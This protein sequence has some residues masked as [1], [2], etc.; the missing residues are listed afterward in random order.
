MVTRAAT[1]F[2]LLLLA[3]FPAAAQYHSAD[4]NADQQISLSEL[5]RVIQFFNS[6]GLHCQANTEDGYAPGAGNTAC[7]PHS[8]DY[9]PQDWTMSVSELLRT[10]QFFN[11]GGYHAGCGTEDRFAPGVDSLSYCEGDVWFV[12]SGASGDGTS[13]DSAFASIQDAVDAAYAAGGGE[14]WVAA[15]SYTGSTDPVLLMR[16]NTAIYGG[17]VGTEA[18]RAERDWENNET[19]INGESER[20]CVY[21]AN[22]AILDGCVIESGFAEYDG[23]SE[24]GGGMFNDT[25]SPTVNN[26]SFVGNTAYYGGGMCN[27]SS[28]PI[29]NGC[30]FIGNEGDN[31]AGIYNEYSS[32]IL[33]GCSFCFNTAF[34]CG[35]GMSDASSSVILSNCIFDT[36]TGRG[37]PLPENWEYYVKS[38]GGALCS[39]DSGLT[40][41][42][43]AFTGNHADDGGGV[44][45]SNASPVTFNNCEFTMNTGAIG[46]GLASYSSS[47][48]ISNCTFFQNSVAFKSYCIQDIFDGEICY[49]FGGTGGGMSNSGGSPAV[50]NCLFFG[51]TAS[52]TVANG[53]G[54]YNNH[55]SPFICNCTLTQNSA[56]YGGGIYNMAYSPTITNSILWDDVGCSE[57][58]EI[59]CAANTFS[60]VVTFSCVQ[61][62]RD[63]QG[64]ISSDPLLLGTADSE[65]RISPMSPCIDTGTTTGAPS[66]DIRGVARFQGNG[67]DMGVYEL[68]D[69]DG[70]GISDTWEETHFGSL[71]GA[72]V[73]SDADGDGLSDLNESL[74]GTDPALQDTD[75][76]GLSDGEEAQ[77]GLNPTAPS[78]FRRVRPGE[79][80]GIPDGLSWETAFVT[81]Q[82]AVDAVAA[83]G[84]GEV[85][86]A[87]G[88]YTGAGAYVVMMK[89][90]VHIYGG[91]A[92]TETSRDERD[93]EDNRTII[94]GE[95]ARRCVYGADHA[96][97]NGFIVRKGYAA[98][99]GGGMHNRAVSPL[100]AN[101][102]FFENTGYYGGGMGNVNSSPRLSNCI[103]TENSAYDG[104]GMH[105]VSSYPVLANCTLLGNI[106]T[107]AGTGI[108]NIDSSPN[109]VNCILWDCLL[110]DTPKEIENWTT[111]SVPVITYSCVRG[112]YDGPGNIA[113]DP[114][115]RGTGEMAGRIQPT[116]PCID[117][118]TILGAAVSD[119]RGV[120]RPQGSGSDMGA[121]EL[122]DSDGDGISDSWEQQHFG[123]LTSA[124]ASSDGDAD[125]LSDLQESLYGTNPFLTD[126]DGDGFSDGEE[127]EHEWEPLLPTAVRRVSSVNISGTEDGLSWATA[128]S[129]IQAAIDDVAVV[130]EGEVWVR[131]GVYTG[132]GD[133][134]GVLKDHVHLYG[135][136]AGTETNHNE[137]DWRMNP[138]IID[139]ESV[140]RC[141]H[142]SGNTVLDGFTV[143]NGAGLDGGGMYNDAFSE[144]GVCHCI[145]SGNSARRHGGGIF[146]DNHASAVVTDC[147]FTRNAA[148]VYGGGIAAD[149]HSSIAIMNCVFTDN[150]AGLDGGAVHAAPTSTILVDNCSFIKNTTH[151]GGGGI[152]GLGS[153]PSRVVNCTFTGN[154]ASIEGGAIQTGYCVNSAPEV[155]NCILWGDGVTS[156]VSEI[157]ND[158]LAPEVTYSCVEG[159]YAGTGN[160]SSDPL[161]IGTEGSQGRIRPASPCIDTGT[162]NAAPATDIRGVLRPKGGGVDMGAYE[163]DDSDADGI[164]DA[165]EQA[166]FGNLVDPSLASD[167]DGD[168]MTDLQESLYGTN[169]AEVDS[170]GDGLTDAQETQQG[171]EPTT[172]TVVRRVDSANASGTED[173]LSWATAFTTIQAGIDAVRDAG[174]GEIWIAGGT[175]TA[176]NDTVV[177]MQR[178]VHLYGGFAGM[179]TT[180]DERDWEINETIIDG[181]SLHQGVWS[182]P[183]THF[184]GFTVQNGRAGYG[185]G[186]N[187]YCSN[188]SVTNCIFRGNTATVYGGGM[189][190]YFSALMMDHCTFTGNTAGSDGGGMYGSYSDLTVGNCTFIGNAAEKDGGGMY[191]ASSKLMLSN[192]VF[193][194]N[195]AS[196]NE[197]DC[198]E[199]ELVCMGDDCEYVCDYNLSCM[200]ARGGGGV[201]NDSS[202]PI[203]VNCTFAGNTAYLNG[204]GIHNEDSSAPVLR[205]LIL[206]EDSSYGLGQEVYNSCDS[207]AVITY[208]CIA[209]GYTGEG[210]LSSDPLFVD[211]ANG[212]LRLQAGSP[213][214][215]TGTADGA[216]S[217][218]ILGITR[219]QGAGYDMGA[220]EYTPD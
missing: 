73:N 68:D 159:G 145:F 181:E 161:L 120:A 14:V 190:N 80:S 112:G 102:T 124:S 78:V 76:D 85:W 184:D 94:D 42:D 31:G 128:F 61:G 170:D 179:E 111:S 195:I 77:R 41:N 30:A 9:A 206:W 46:A 28:S 89:S 57:G 38:S 17:F 84:D 33:N 54:I 186:M 137:R 10:I 62:G 213:C 210:N 126:S 70:D 8:S 18:A 20:C 12:K 95:S 90:W 169:P 199:C 67:V 25:V 122:D 105:N 200:D 27:E 143:R 174:E 149:W 74:Y 212:D 218:D 44:S 75:G 22:N 53:G 148:S 166:N 155:T 152:Y 97:L 116:S 93:W 198:Y 208:S 136:F 154:T 138:T 201:Y 40:A 100:V 96:T 178:R 118:G 101:C 187:N 121:Y 15:G 193:L 185:G 39:S 104:G 106:A 13:W 160:I 177:V 29:L 202:S 107:A 1:L 167:A 130:G 71:T 45:V 19:I 153:A 24:Y 127:T 81:I 26:C 48:V 189:Y 60:P 115:P 4:T 23:V 109:L 197:D 207:S 21:G 150:E 162:L 7:V 51:N 55:S 164:S 216:P 6:G 163:L 165:W 196:G 151:H 204:G 58:N 211:A 32:T 175:Y 182:A 220:Y 129:S 146:N 98:G 156:N 168:G 147:T 144:I 133:D 50:S 205:N 52:G 79:P 203:I 56:S 119:I 64:N 219:P 110:A 188:V 34:Y 117:A 209:G 180:R 141:V 158:D 82:A 183:D 142:G 191:D 140:R 2:T 108:C 123:N 215:D 47:P 173:G 171:W 99:Y 36:N 37:G 87:A 192:S 91:F 16:E 43:C 157:Q 135:G 35:G 5:L 131:T 11:S 72:S 86:V 132:N 172:P 113:S 92:G 88:T 59:Y 103:F 125:G 134:V 63:G 139:G 214:I 176:T 217:T 69:S 114:L 194:E 83:V 66:T 65:G 49:E 3:A